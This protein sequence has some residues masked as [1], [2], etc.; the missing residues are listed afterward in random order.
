M[1]YPSPSWSTQTVMVMF[2]GSH[3]GLPADRAAQ[4]AKPY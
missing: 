1:A 2:D 4:I 3:I